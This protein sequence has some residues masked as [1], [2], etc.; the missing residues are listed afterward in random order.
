AHWSAFTLETQHF[1]DGPNQPS[2]P[3][4]R[5]DPGQTYTQNTVLKFS[6]D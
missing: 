5:L 6:A 2:F 3:S 1:P 4:T